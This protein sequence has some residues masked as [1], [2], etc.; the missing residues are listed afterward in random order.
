MR[1]AGLR[2]CARM[3]RRLLNLL[4]ALSLLLCV[5]LCALWVRTLWRQDVV[6][7]PGRRHN[8]FTT[9]H[10][11]WSATAG[12]P[13]WEGPAYESYEPNRKFA[14]TFGP[15]FGYSR[16]PAPGGSRHA[17]LGFAY[18]SYLQPPPN[19]CRFTYIAVPLWAFVAL[20]ALMP[21]ERLRRRL[22]RR[23]VGTCAFCG[24]DLR[25]TPGRC[26]ECGTIAAATP[27]A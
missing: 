11:V 13:Y 24:Y 7:F 12:R 14:A 8:L 21:A 5:A 19:A 2:H 4:T 23:R 1:G 9:P 15:F 22:R 26:P 27:P 20:S 17:A 25:A 16:R 3:K 6:R 10:V 18:L